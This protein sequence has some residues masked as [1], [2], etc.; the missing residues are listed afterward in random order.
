MSVAV[1]I[2]VHGIAVDQGARLR[3]H[4]IRAGGTLLLHRLLRRGLLDGS[5]GLLGQLVGWY[6]LVQRQGVAIAIRVSSA[7][8]VA[9]MVELLAL[10]GS[11]G[12]D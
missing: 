2:D 12:T 9:K 4:A 7:V 8:V 6:A 3:L 1:L 5:I 10:R 11:V